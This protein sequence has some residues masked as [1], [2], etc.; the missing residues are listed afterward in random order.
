MSTTANAPEAVLVGID[1]L[2]RLV[3]M[4]R[5]ADRTFAG[6]TSVS[7]D[8]DALAHLVDLAAATN[9]KDHYEEWA[10]SNAYEAL[11]ESDDA[12]LDSVGGCTGASP[13]PSP[14]VPRY[15]YLHDPAIAAED[16]VQT[17]CHCWDHL[18]DEWG[19]AR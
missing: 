1:D 14:D 4:T 16:K 3:M 11:G 6:C 15:C 19:D 9:P 10:M 2:V 13:E 5:F 17:L 8:R 7:I 18:D 12:R